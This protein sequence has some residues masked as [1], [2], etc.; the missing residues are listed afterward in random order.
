MNWGIL[1]Y[2][3]VVEARE[4]IFSF[5]ESISPDD[6]TK[7]VSHFGQGSI[8]KTQEHI[9]DSYIHWIANY[10]LDKSLPYL[11]VE[12]IHSVAEMRKEY[13]KVDKWMAEFLDTHAQNPNAT[14]T[15][16]IGRRG[17]VSTSPL[18]LLTHMITHEFHH[19]GQMMSIARMLGYEPPDTDIIRS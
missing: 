10:A 4:V 7:K 2:D 16:T 9:V 6:Y 19:K 8:R 14:L 5:C 17:A 13:L 11:K 18:V 1:Q 12:S 3:L 15:N